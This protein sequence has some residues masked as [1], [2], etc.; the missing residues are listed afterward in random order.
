MNALIK[1]KKVVNVVLDESCRDA[2]LVCNL[3]LAF[4]EAYLGKI[5]FDV[6]YCQ[7]NN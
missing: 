4:E 6:R 3:Y 2:T 5:L 7:N 1:R